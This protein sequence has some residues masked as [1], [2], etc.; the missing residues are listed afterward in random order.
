[1]IRFPFDSD[2]KRVS[3][4]IENVEGCDYKRLHIKGASEI[5]TACCTH[6]IDER[7]E[8]QSLSDNMKGEISNLI[9]KYARNALRTIAV[10]YKDIQPGQ[11]GERHDEPSDAL[12]KDI[13]KENLTLICIFGIYDIVR[14]EVPGAVGECKTAGIKVRMVTGDN[15]VTAMAIA[16]KCGIL[17]EAEVGNEQICMTGPKFFEQVGGL[18]CGKCKKDI[19]DVCECK[20]KDRIEKVKHFKEFKKIEE[21]LKVVARSRPE[22]KYLLVTGLRQ[23]D[24]TVAVTGDGTN[25]AP[26]LK[27]A[28]VGFAMGITGTDIAKKAADILITDDNF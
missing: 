4:I 14:Q 5:I 19:P 18:K 1:M 2:R 10:A 8:K 27:K 25:D 6:Y 20:A 3:T 17:T 11:N 15:I 9:E 7:G 16:V 24:K 28:D 21:H 22:D 13:E 23:M 26:A 12:V